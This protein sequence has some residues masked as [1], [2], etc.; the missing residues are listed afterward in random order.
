[1]AA[2]SAEPE[3]IE[4]LAAALTRFAGPSESRLTDGWRP[5]TCCEP[6]DA[7]V[8]IVD[9]AAR[10]VA[11]QSTFCDPG[12]AGQ[13]VY[14]DA[15]RDIEVS[16]PYHVSDDWRFVRRLESW[17]SL[18]ESRRRERQAA[19]Q[20]DARGVLYGQVAEFLAVECLAARGPVS[21]ETGST[22]P[23]SPPCASVP[24]DGDSS[25][26]GA[27]TPPVGW[28]LSA[29]PERLKPGAA[30]SSDDA[31]AEI[32]A[33]WLMTPRG[34]LGGLSPRDVLVEKRDHLDWDLQDRGVQWSFTGACPPAL[35]ETSAAF[36]GGGFGTHENVLYY[37]LV[38]HLVWSCW[39]RVVEPAGPTAAPAVT[40]QGDC[41]N[42]RGEVRE[43]GTVP[44]GPRGTGTF[45]GPK[46]PKNEPVPG[47]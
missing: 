11:V 5:G 2:L 34:D 42:F 40:V 35:S 9:L 45:F 6:Y 33:R 12:P 16:L 38:R 20:V 7:G 15:D 32:H 18:A 23:G 1:V 37:G 39:Q 28:S 27:W 31:V 41:P 17:E 19:P 8:A 46:R 25:P 36:R 29:L 14:R 43:N 13:V 21:P 3:T 44:F 22:A 10:L 24:A 47:L 30:I 4:E 26:S